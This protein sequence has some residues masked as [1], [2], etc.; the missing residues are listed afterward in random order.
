M[1]AAS[2]IGTYIFTYI[3]TYA[4]T[5]LHLPARIGFIAELVDYLATI[6][7]ILLAGWLSDRVGRRPINVWGN[8][9][10]LIAIYPVFAWVA[11]RPSVSPRGRHELLGALGNVS[12]G[13]FC[14]GLAEAL[15]Q[16]IRSSGFA[17]VYSVAIAAFGGTAQLVIT[18]LLH[19]TGSALAPAWYLVGATA[20]G[21]V[22]LMLF[23]ETAPVRQGLGTDRF[24]SVACR[25]P[26]KVRLSDKAPC[27]PPGES[28]EVLYFHPPRRIVPR[29]RT[30]AGLAR[31]HGSVRAEIAAGRVAR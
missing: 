1:L 19:I 21:Q 30:T 23:P 25:S 22:A 27:S 29:C 6:P 14:A 9:A 4:Q 8:L 10:F 16:N 5:T 20:V 24:S 2:T 31:C 11:A 7:T 26:M 28:D 17:T 18:W 12:F 3:V 13:A 15:P